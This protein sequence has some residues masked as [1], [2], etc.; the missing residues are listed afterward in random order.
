MHK[1]FK[2]LFLIVFVSCSGVSK[3]NET[4]TKFI[5]TVNVEPGKIIQINL[6]SSFRGLDI[7]CSNGVYP[8]AK[9]KNPY[10]IYAESYFSDLEQKSCKA[11]NIEIKIV[12]NEKNFPF[13]ELKVDRKR[14][15]LNK[16]DL[17]RVLRER[18]VLKKVY[19]G[20][21]SFMKIYNNFKLPL[22]SKITSD[23]GK[24]RLFNKERKGQHLGIDFRAKIGKEISA[25]NDGSVVLAQ[26]LFYTGNT[27]I[28][29]HGLGIFTVYGHLSKINVSLGV[30]VKK[31]DIVGLAGMTGRV[32]GP[33]LHWGVKVNGQW[34]NGKDLLNIDL[35]Y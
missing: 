33:H 23:Y 35:R 19:A 25:A 27:V 14:V 34:V 20:Q 16:K 28:L 7:K 5:D 17:K 4:D 22:N 30:K 3:Y 18:E 10:F 6:P 2:A 8:V 11:D 9:T 15:N 1:F 29:Y 13:E 12:V 21:S 26:S 24:R 31:D 32:T